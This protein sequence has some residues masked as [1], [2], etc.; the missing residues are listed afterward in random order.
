MDGGGVGRSEQVAAVQ[1]A[2][3]GVGGESQEQQTVL[4]QAPPAPSNPLA[5]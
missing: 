5:G 1:P 2:A 3:G 4:Y